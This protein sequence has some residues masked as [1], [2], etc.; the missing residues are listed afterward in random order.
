MNRQ[1]P[2]GVQ[3]GRA[4][5]AANSPSA[6]SSGFIPRSR[7]A[8][9]EPIPLDGEKVRALRGETSRAALHLRT[10]ELG[11]RVS[12][13]NIERIERDGA[14]ARAFRETIE[15]LAA[16]LGVEPDAIR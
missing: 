6:P 2:L 10:V 14:D 12:A 1:A 5:A 15:A 16:A 11:H 7:P 4:L 8:A 9:T 13:E 3:V